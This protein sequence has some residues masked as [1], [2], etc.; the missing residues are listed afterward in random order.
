MEFRWLLLENWQ[1]LP[2]PHTAPIRLIQ[3][4]IEPTNT[5]QFYHCRMF[6]LFP[7]HVSLQNTTN[8]QTYTDL[9]PDYT[10]FLPCLHT[11]QK[12]VISWF[13]FSQRV[14]KLVQDA[15]LFSATNHLWF[16]PLFNLKKHQKGSYRLLS[17]GL[18]I[19]EYSAGHTKVICN[20]NQ[21]LCHILKTFPIKDQGK[22]DLLDF[23]Q[24]NFIL[25]R[26]KNV[27]IRVAEVMNAWCGI[28]Q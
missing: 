20:I 24:M 17:I 18:W 22:S 3:H 28:A 27:W 7:K 13:H 23:C 4:H 5:M 6:F 11:N 25:F 14:L 16:D 19:Y 15:P 12:F 26:R 2:L 10:S 1:H 9:K 21:V 8:T